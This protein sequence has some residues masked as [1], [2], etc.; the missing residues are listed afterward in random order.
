MSEAA[1]VSTE[2]SELLLGRIRDI[3]DYPK[4]G[5]MFKDITPLLADPEAFTVLTDSLARICAERGATK[6][7][8]LEAR[9]FIL[10]APVAVRAGVGFIPVRKAGKLPGATLSQ[11][12]ELEYGTAEM[13][14]H[15][16]D[17]SSDDRVL[18]VDDVLATGGTAEASLE[19]IRRAGAQ[20]VGLA[21]LME[22]GFLGGRERLAPALKD[23][24]LDAL[25]TV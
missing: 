17:L 18:I 9:G 24:E 2:V 13:E 19:L 23:A 16:E 20:V 21:V 15:A 4:P 10:A 22:L 14:V 5:V 1:P 12:Y 3:A 8:G 11:E 7:V 6:V 25:V